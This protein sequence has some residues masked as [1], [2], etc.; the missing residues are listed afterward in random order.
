MEEVAGKLPFSVATLIAGYESSPVGGGLSAASVF[1]LRA[2][3]RRPLILKCAESFSD[4]DLEDE[5]GRLRW[6]S[7]RTIVPAPLACGATVQLQYLLMDVIP[8][9]DASVA[10][11]KP[12]AIIEGMARALRELHAQPIADCPYDQRLDAQVTRARRRVDFGLVDETDFDEERAGRS[13][14]GL[15]AEVERSRPPDEDLVL[16]HGDACFPN[17]MFEDGRFTGFV[18]L[19][20]A[21][22]ADRYQDVALARRS[23]YHNLGW[24]WIEPFFEEYGMPE[25]DEAKLRFYELLDELF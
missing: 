9:H 25:P 21:G 24:D 1:A 2:E 22:V 17:V 15:L 19:G 8:G 11:T 6:F 14:A 23:I 4:V 12:S 16:T 7:S 3:G 13:A 10:G 20:R 18:D 5:A